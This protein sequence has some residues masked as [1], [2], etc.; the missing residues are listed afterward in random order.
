MNEIENEIDRDHA[1]ELLKLRG[2]IAE[3]TRKELDDSKIKL[4]GK[5]KSEGKPRSTTID[6][7]Y[8]KKSS[9][10]LVFCMDTCICSN[11]MLF[12]LMEWRVSRYPN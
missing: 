9:I 3:D 8:L 6:K 11:Y 10:A 12:P 2:Q 7:N 4:F 5:L 1:E